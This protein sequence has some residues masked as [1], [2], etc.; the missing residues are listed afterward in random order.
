MIFRIFS[1]VC[2]VDL[3]QAFLSD[4]QALTEVFFDF[5]LKETHIR[6]KGKSRIE[7]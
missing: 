4:F 7:V 3:Q 1:E 5:L 6:F 2:L